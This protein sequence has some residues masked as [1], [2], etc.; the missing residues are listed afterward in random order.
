MLRNP[1][2]NRFRLTCSLQIVYFVIC[3]LLMKRL[4]VFT[5]CGILFAVYKSTSA[6]TISIFEGQIFER[7]NQSII[8]FTCK[9]NQRPID[10][11]IVFLLNEQTSNVMRFL[12]GK[13][14][15][16]YEE[17]TECKCFL[18]QNKMTFT[19]VYIMHVPGNNC[20]FG[21][22]MSITNDENGNTMNVNLYRRYNGKG[23]LE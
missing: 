5:T 20:T 18:S 7:N 15:N 12:D 17:D 1:G 9:I 14:H 13:C 16:T 10:D 4:I 8:E 21:T 19:W 22:E 2:H 23:I 11:S 6:F 3:L